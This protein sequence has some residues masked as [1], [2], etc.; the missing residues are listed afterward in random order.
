MAVTGEDSGRIYAYTD[1]FNLYH[2]MMENEEWGALRWLDHAAVARCL[3]P[4]EG[5]VL[6][7]QYF[8]SWVTEPDRLKRQRQ[9]LVALEAHADLRIHYGRFEKQRIKCR[10]CEKRFTRPHEKETDVRLATAL[11]ADAFDDLYDTIL[12]ISA[13]A[14]LAPAVEYVKE[15]F[16]KRLL[17][18]D[19]PN[20]HSDELLALSDYSRTKIPKKTLEDCQLPDPVEIRT[21]GG[22]TRRIYRPEAWRPD[23]TF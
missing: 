17:L 2:G 13:D 5:S 19:P 10:K 8:T 20:R 11:V 18:I 9:Y 6:C 21:K 12:L 1:G 23:S 3:V 14:D 15:R 4:D 7:V 16:G 22:R